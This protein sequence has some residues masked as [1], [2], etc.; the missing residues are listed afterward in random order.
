MN[1]SELEVIA[2]KAELALMFFDQDETDKAKSKVAEIQ[3]QAS[4]ITVKA[5]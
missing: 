1:R 5:S 3:Y 2:K 4:K